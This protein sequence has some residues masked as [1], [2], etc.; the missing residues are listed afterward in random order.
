MNRRKAEGIAPCRIA[1]EGHGGAAGEQIHFTAIDRRK[2]LAGAQV[3]ELHL[4]GIGEHPSGD[5]TAE[6]HLKALVAAI[7]SDK[8]EARQLAINAADQLPA[9]FHRGQFLALGPRALHSAAGEDET[10]E[11]RK[12]SKD[13]AGGKGHQPGLIS[14]IV[15]SVFKAGPSPMRP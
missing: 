15:P 5:R 9:G 8:T 2:A 4:G 14:R 6:V 13:L 1:A 3:A 11:Q 12:R 10:S 7:G